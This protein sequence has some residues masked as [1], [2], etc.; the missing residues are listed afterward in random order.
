[1]KARGLERASLLRAGLMP[2]LLLAAGA[3]AA[4]WACVAWAVA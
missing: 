4:L 3:L 1:M 2:R